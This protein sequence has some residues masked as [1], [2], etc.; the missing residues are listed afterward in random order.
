MDTRGAAMAANTARAARARGRAWKPGRASGNR[1]FLHASLR[2][3]ATLA[4]ALPL[5]ACGE[6]RLVVNVDVLSFVPEPERELAYGPIP[7][8]LSGSVRSAP[9]E[10]QGP[11]GVG[12]STRIDSVTIFASTDVANASGSADAEIELFFDTA[13]ATLYAGEPALAVSATLAPNATTAVP[14]TAPLPATALHVFNAATFYA[15]VRIRLQ[16]RDPLGGPDLQG[17][18]RVME[19]RARVVAS[20]NIFR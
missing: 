2:A 12:G 20:Q 9:Y 10:V 5:A 1:N 18:A 7:A 19:F 13:A 8:G 4:L 15:G 3:C 6:G 16:S 11:E 14:I 17:T